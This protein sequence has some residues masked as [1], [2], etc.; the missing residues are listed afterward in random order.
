MPAGGM[1]RGTKEGAARRRKRRRRRER[2]AGESGVLSSGKDADGRGTQQGDCGNKA[3][4][5]A[6]TERGACTGTRGR[7]RG[8]HWAICPR[9][10]R[11]AELRVGGG[12]GELLER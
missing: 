10:P 8:A 12:C 4:E 7:G 3:Q 5:L 2:S 9:L 11:A 1:E 6:G